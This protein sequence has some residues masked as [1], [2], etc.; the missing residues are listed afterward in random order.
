LR[1]VQIFP[2]QAFVLFYSLAVENECSSVQYLLMQSE[3]YKL[4]PLVSIYEVPYSFSIITAS[5]GT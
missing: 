4:K 3:K 2:Y 1:D 5:T